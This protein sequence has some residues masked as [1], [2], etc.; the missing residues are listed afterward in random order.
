MS[1]WV[2]I[3]GLALSMLIAYGSLAYRLGHQSARVEAIERWRVNM[4][5]DMH[6]ISDKIS[7][8]TAAMEKL[9]TL[10]NERTERRDRGRVDA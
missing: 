5:D 7:E 1:A 10:I 6:E 4:R 8:M 9:S 2:G 3:V